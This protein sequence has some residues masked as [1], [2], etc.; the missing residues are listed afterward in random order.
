MTVAQRKPIRMPITNI[1]TGGD[2]SARFELGSASQGVNLILDTGSSSLAVSRQGYAPARD[3]HMQ[4]TAY[5][6]NISYGGGSWA[7]PVIKT[8]LRLPATDKPMQLS[9]VNLGLAIDQQQ[10][11]FRQAD[12][13]FGLAYASLNPAYNLSQLLTQHDYQPAVTY[14]WPLQ[15]PHQPLTGEQIQQFIE[16]HNPVEHLP[17]TFNHI[18]Q[19]GI[20]ADQFAFYTRRSEVHLQTHGETLEQA[21]RDPLNQ[22][23]FI[24]GG[25]AEQRDLYRGDFTSIKICHDTFY[26]TE[27]LALQLGERPIIHIDPKAQATADDAGN[28]IIDSG[29]NVVLFAGGLYQQ[30]LNDFHALNP[31]FPDMIQHYERLIED[32]KGV[33][34]DDLQLAQWPPLHLH[35]SGTDGQPVALT[36]SPQSYWQVNAPAPGQARF[37]LRGASDSGSQRSIL[38]LPLLNN[39]YTVF[40]RAFDKLGAIHFATLA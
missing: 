12:G 9:A 31:A 22:G 4:A 11:A 33:A 30:L 27:L 23:F 5:A 36:L 8:S 20:L 32:G 14:P 1:Y 39:Y 29:T 7:G 40:D 34:V 35:L 16:Q 28:A 6:Q 13:I 3:Q 18:E 2:Y 38:G 19:S 21:L 37:K 17:T 25:G 10:S 26:T 24:L 15:R